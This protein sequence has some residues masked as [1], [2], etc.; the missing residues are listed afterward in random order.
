LS[1]DTD[2]SP[3]EVVTDG[4]TPAANLSARSLARRLASPEGWLRLATHGLAI[5]LVSAAIWLARV[6]FTRQPVLNLPADLAPAVSTATEVVVVAPEVSATPP[7]ELGSAM[8][9][10]DPGDV[11]RLADIHTIIPSRPRYEVS[12]YTVEAND[13]L[14]IIASKF[15]LDPETILWG[16]PTLADNPNLLSVGQELNILP[17]DGALRIV[18]AGDTLEKIATAYHGTVEDIVNFPGNDLD[19]SDP[20]IANGM[21]IIIP[22]GWRDSV[23]WQL[24]VVTRSTGPSANTGE[25]GSCSGPFSG[26]TG[27]NTFVWPANN[28]YLSGT[29]YLPQGHPGIDIAAG[30]GAP[31][32]A[33]DTGVIVFAGLSYRGYGN[34][35]IIDHGNGWQT[36]YAHLSQINVFCG[37]SIFQGQVLG[38]SGSTGNSTGAH[39]HFEMRHSQFGRVNPWLYLP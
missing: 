19:P 7:P 2:L 36:A 28:H 21:Y 18:Q 31:L 23:A 8:P 17:V 13:T 12:R 38:L 24:P 30:M 20:V 26:P 6:D 3:A 14:F 10:P 22:G 25:P 16:N 34:L 4:R 35:V 15:N 39:L 5:G 32:Y 37:G 33:S 29:D 27:S 11:G 9:S 1:T